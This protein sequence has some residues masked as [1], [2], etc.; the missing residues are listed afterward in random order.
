[1]VMDATPHATLNTDTLALE[2]EDTISMYDGK[3]VEME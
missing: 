3:N 2:E 1:M